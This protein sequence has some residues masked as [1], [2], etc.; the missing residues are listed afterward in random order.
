VGVMFENE[1]FEIEEG[2]FVRNLLTDL[3]DCFPSVFR[4]RFGAV[5]TLLIGYYIFYFKRLLQ[6]G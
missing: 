4:I 3:D 2:A 1:L 5:R 6:D